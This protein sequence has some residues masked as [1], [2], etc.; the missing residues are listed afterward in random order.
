MKFLNA[1]L[2]AFLLVAIP[3]VL[4]FNVALITL[5]IGLYWESAEHDDAKAWFGALLPVVLVVPFPSYFFIKKSIAFIKNG[6][7]GN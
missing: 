7:S 1:I 2:F 4:V 3:L 5:W 6:M